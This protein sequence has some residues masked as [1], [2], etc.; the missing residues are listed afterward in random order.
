MI[1]FEDFPITVD[2]KAEQVAKDV[3]AIC[4]KVAQDNRENAE[5]A[6]VISAFSRRATSLI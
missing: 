1:N 3:E 5:S 2:E 4:L 6:Y